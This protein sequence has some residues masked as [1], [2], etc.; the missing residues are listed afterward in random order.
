MELVD[1][2]CHL[3]F[4]RLKGRIK[5][6]LADAQ[7]AGVK[8]LIC[9]GTTLEDSAQAVEIAG[10]HL[11]VWASI[12]VHPHDVKT[13]SQ[14]KIGQFK[15]LLDRPKVVALGEVGLDYYRLYS[16]KDQQL[17]ALRAQIEASLGS[18]LPF[19]FHVR[20]AFPDFWRLF[21][22]YPNLGGVVHSFSAG[23]AELDQILSRGLYVG[24]NGIVTFSQ[25]PS[26]LAAA[27]A[28]PADRLVLETDAP[29]L[30][31]APYRGVVCQPKYIRDIAEFLAELRSEKL[32]QLAA[33]TTN[34]AVKLFG[35][36]EAPGE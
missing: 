29:F 24:L 27:K 23:P 36:G 5:P 34:N 10:A 22:S 2:H 8:R 31:P 17:A 3:Q 18:G 32:E 6:V 14:V 35:L 7:A 11:N 9:V 12:G 33:A 16:P 28:L 30:A 21:D 13:F 26:Q 25:S 19:I 4:A 15:K 20:Q 1:T